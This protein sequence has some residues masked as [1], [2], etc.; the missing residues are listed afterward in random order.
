MIYCICASLFAQQPKHQVALFSFVM[1][2][3][4]VTTVK[5]YISSRTAAAVHV[6]S[7]IIRKTCVF[8]LLTMFATSCVIA[9]CVIIIKNDIFGFTSMIFS[10]SP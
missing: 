9:G 5:I 8:A 4:K 3:L 2:R 1:N 10:S 7:V 6:Y